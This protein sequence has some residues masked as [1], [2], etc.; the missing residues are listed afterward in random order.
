MAGGRSLRSSTEQVAAKIEQ[1]A[2]RRV[3]SV[4]IGAT[5]FGGAAFHMNGL[6]IIRAISDFSD[7]RFSVNR[8]SQPPL[9]VLHA[10]Y[11]LSVWRD[12]PDLASSMVPTLLKRQMGIYGGEWGNDG[13]GGA[14]GQREG[15]RGSGTLDAGRA[16][17]GMDAGSYGGSSAA[18]QSRDR[19]STRL[20]KKPKP[21]RSQINT[22]LDRRA[23]W[24]LGAYV[25]GFI[26]GCVRASTMSSTISISVL[27]SL[28][29]GRR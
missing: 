23:C 16:G 19:P 24:R 21:A 11:V 2:A 14:G 4:S 26:V 27:L 9:R 13:G 7:L 20:S 15:G 10:A 28:G 25:C 29:Y 12:V 17:R 1:S 5:C 8:P 18:A 22:V 6:S 3:L